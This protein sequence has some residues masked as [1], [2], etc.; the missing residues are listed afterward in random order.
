V[1]SGGC[2]A[3]ADPDRV[4]ARAKQ[5]GHHQLG[6]L[7]S[8]NRRPR[9]PCGAIPGKRTYRTGQQPRFRGKTVIVRMWFILCLVFAAPQAAA[10][11]TPLRIGVSIAPQA[12]LVERLAGQPVEVEVMVRPGQSPATVDPTPRQMA[13]LARVAAYIRI[14]VPFERGFIKRLRHNRPQ[15]PIID[16]RQGV[17]LLTRD[18]RALKPGADPN[19]ADP[20]IWL[21][22]G[23]LKRQADT[24]A[25]ALRDLAPQRAA[26]I[27]DRRRRLAA[28]LDRLDGRIGRLLEPMRG[29]PLFVFHPAY[30]YFAAAYGLVQVAVQTGGKEPSARQLARL[31]ERARRAKARVIFVQPQYSRKSAELVAEAIGAAVVELDPLAPNVLNNLQRVAERVAQA[32]ERRSAP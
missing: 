28:E 14:G 25:R 12:W 27:E 13:A 24:V 3:G 10:A 7:G 1:E 16:Q 21:D 32:F 5:R 31:I 9:L 6:T 22:P 23:R 8:G 20:H 29:Q 30:G 19:A 4:S 26:A 2:I 17:V 11:E 18:G 15:L